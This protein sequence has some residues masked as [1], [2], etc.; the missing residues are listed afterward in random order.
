MRAFAATF[1]CKKKN[2]RKRIALQVFLQTS[3][4]VE[5]EIKR[6]AR[7]HKVWSEQNIHKYR[8]THTFDSNKIILLARHSTL[9]AWRRSDICNRETYDLNIMT[10]S[11]ARHT[12]R[13][14]RFWRLWDFLQTFGVVVAIAPRSFHLVIES[15]AFGLCLEDFF[16]ALYLLCF[17]SS[18]QMRD[19]HVAKYCGLFH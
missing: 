4:D 16:S 17:L 8:H 10:D 19:D 14:I 15:N 18:E 5:E 3:F 11:H 9:M 2:Q 13:S 12:S 7:V 1:K 6:G